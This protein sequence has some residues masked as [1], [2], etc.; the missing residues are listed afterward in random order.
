MDVMHDFASS[1]SGLTIKRS[2]FS[3]QPHV[4]TTFNAGKLVPLGHPFEV[5]PGDTIRMD[6]SALVRMITPYAPVM[7]DA[8]LDVYFFWTPLRQLWNHFEEEQGANKSTFWDDPT[9]WIEPRLENLDDVAVGNPLDYL[10]VPPG[11][12]AITVSALPLSNYLKIWDEWFRDENLQVPHSDVSI[13][14][15]AGNNVDVYSDLSFAASDQLLDVNKY[16]D[17]F[18]SCLPSPQ[19]GDAVKVPVGGQA[20]LEVGDAVNKF[21]VQDLAL[22]LSTVSP[23]SQ[24]SSYSLGVNGGTNLVGA[25]AAG[26][27]TPAPNFINGTNLYADLSKAT[28]ATVNE[29]RLAFQTQK[30]LERDARGGTRYVEMLKSHFGVAPSSEILNRSELLGSIHQRL[31][32]TQV[33]QTSQPSTP[34]GDNSVGSTGAYSATGLNKSAFVKSFKEYGY[35]QALCCVRVKHSYGQ[36]LHKVWTRFRRFDRYYPEFANV[37]EMPI[38]KREIL[39]KDAHKDEVFGFNE[40]FVEYRYFENQAT[41]LMRPDV[42]GSVGKTWSYVDDFK[43]VALNSDFIT[44]RPS[45]I[46]NTIIYQSS[47]GPVQFKAD[48]MFDIKATRPM[49]VKSYPGLI[50]HN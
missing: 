37:G 9:D 7:D 44:E 2:T 6:C 8:Y 10:G 21:S 1:D 19:K 13:I 27:S 35:V 30:L 17:L 16:H 46:D 39:A 25:S 18:T 26:S 41:G 3:G 50:D 48:F 31:N 36:G 24:G 12:G 34:S 47:N 42:E 4:R 14:Y 33:N 43:S 29:L 11:A 22:K 40:A 38:Y 5:L 28:G 45:N 20:P 32:M 15:N 49:P 23:I